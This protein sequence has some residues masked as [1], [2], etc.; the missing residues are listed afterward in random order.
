MKKGIIKIRPHKGEIDSNDNFDHH[1]TGGEINKLTSTGDCWFEVFFSVIQPETSSTLHVIKKFED[2]KS[3][4]AYFKEFAANNKLS[5]GI[6]KK[7]SC[8]E[9][10]HYV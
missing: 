7:V 2:E 4:T 8:Q 9:L 1:F 10:L 5:E 6:L 3:A